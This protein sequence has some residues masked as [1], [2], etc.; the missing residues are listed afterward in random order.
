VLVVSAWGAGPFENDDA[1]DL[2]IE[3]A[4]GKAADCTR[5]VRAV[6]NLPVGYLD[7]HVSSAAVAA[8]A[9]VAMANGMPLGGPVQAVEV[10]EAGAVPA[11]DEVRQ[12]AGR[13]LAR[14]AGEDSE[15]RDLW[16]D[17]GL[18]T[19]AM[20]IFEPIRAHL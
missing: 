13:A 16:D 17:V 8:A 6:L 7:V 3:L 9:L 5:Q 12:L 11:D 20:S 15:W 18:L 1:L 4:H 10:V 14:V 2:L 19:D